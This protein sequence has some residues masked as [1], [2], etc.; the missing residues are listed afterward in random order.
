VYLSYF[1]GLFNMRAADIITIKY[2]PFS[3]GVEPANF[4]SSGKH[5]NHKTIEDDLKP[6]YGLQP[7]HLS[8]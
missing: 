4:W 3:L 8:N 5:A 7:A 2:P 6:Y 1:E